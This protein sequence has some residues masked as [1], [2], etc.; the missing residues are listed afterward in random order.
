MTGLSILHNYG[1]EIENRLRL[2]TFPL[3][4]KLLEKEADIPQGAQRPLKDLG[5]KL[6][7]CQ[8]FAMSRRDGATVAMLKE[9]MW[10]F[11]PVIGYGIEKPPQYF[12]DG[13]N[14]FPHDVETLE[15]GRNF[16][17]QFPRLEYGKY[18]GVMSAPLTT[19]SF[20]PDLVMI[21]C[22]TEQLNLLLLGREYKDGG[23]LKCSLSAHAV[24]VYSVVPV[25]QND[26]Y[27]VA[28][29][30]GGDRR[31]AIAKDYEMVFTVS[32]E[33]LEELLLGLRYIEEHG[34][35]KLPRTYQ[36]KPEPTTSE[37]YEKIARTLGMRR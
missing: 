32:Q 7:A 31:T 11:E 25:M 33:K 36:M 12:L 16:A 30:C 35:S 13:Y 5:C 27:Y 18:I 24:C 22:N 15:A 29:P 6:M 21:Y 9:D 20:E 3:A 26:D 17:S 14:R 2:Q 8:G 4:I 10:C 34:D 28:I 23:N 19:T 37:P 1:K